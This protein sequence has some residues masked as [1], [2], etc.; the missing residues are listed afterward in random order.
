MKYLLLVFSLSIF[1][2]WAMAS[3]CSS[4]RT[5][6]A[7]VSAL[8]EGR[9]RG[10]YDVLKLMLDT[11]LLTQDIY[12]EALTSYLDKANTDRENLMVPMANRLK[13]ECDM[14]DDLYRK[15]VEAKYIFLPEKN[16]YTI[17]PKN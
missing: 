1:P 16:A 7:G 2:T 4:K 6:Y 10:Q 5:A 11:K 17:S 12:K 3:D 15:A 9:I 14:P 8:I 13:K